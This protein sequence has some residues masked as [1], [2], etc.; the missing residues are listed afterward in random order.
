MKDKLI[1]AYQWR[2]L[3]AKHAT[4]GSNQWHGAI[5]D[6]AKKHLRDAEI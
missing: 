2:D 4:Q 6:M 3:Q 1:D 5:L